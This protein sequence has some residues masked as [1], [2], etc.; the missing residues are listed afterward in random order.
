MVSVAIKQESQEDRQGHVAHVSSGRS[1]NRIS[2]AS[3]ART[4]NTTHRITKKGRIPKPKKE[5]PPAKRRVRT[6]CLTCRRKHKK[7]DENRPKC[8]FCTSKGLEC[9]WPEEVKKNVFVNNS[10]KD[11]CF[12]PKHS[13]SRIGRFSLPDKMV[14]SSPSRKSTVSLSDEASESLS[15]LEY[16]LGSDMKPR[17]SLDYSELLSNPSPSD[18]NL[19]PQSHYRRPK[20]AYTTE[21]NSQYL[22][23]FDGYTKKNDFIEDNLSLNYPILE[24]SDSPLS[25]LF[26]TLQESQATGPTLAAPQGAGLLRTPSFTANGFDYL[27]LGG[28]QGVA[29]DPLNSNCTAVSSVPKNSSSSA[30]S[31]TSEMSLGKKEADFEHRYSF[32]GVS[33]GFHKKRTVESSLKDSSYVFANT[34]VQHYE[35]PNTL[36]DFM[37]LVAATKDTA[38]GGNLPN[39]E[40]IFEF[41]ADKSTMEVPQLEEEEIMLLMDTYIDEIAAG[42]NKSDEKESNVFSTEI[43]AMAEN[44]P[45]LK[46]ALLALSSRHLEKVNSMYS[47]EKTLQLYNFALQQLSFSLNSNKDTLGVV[48]ACVLLCYFE[49]ISTEAH[50]WRERLSTCGAMFKACRINA[51]AEN[52]LARALFWSFESMDIGCCSIG[53]AATIIP[54]DEWL[55]QEDGNKTDWLESLKSMDSEFHSMMLLTAKV[56]HLMSSNDE[57]MDF[58][59]DW[60][61]LWDCLSTWEI[62]RSNSMRSCFSYKRSDSFPEVLFSSPSAISSNQLFHMCCIV[63]LQNKPRMFKRNQQSVS[64][65][66]KMEEDSTGAVTTGLFHS[67]IS[68][69][70]VLPTAPST[71]PSS[72]PSSLWTTKSPGSSSLNFKSQIWHAKQI[73]GTNL[74]NMKSENRRNLG[75]QILSLQCIWVA[76]KLI[77]SSHEHAI[78]LKLLKDIE[79]WCG[80][81]M[82]WRGKELVEF[83][84]TEC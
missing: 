71:D 75:C 31:I 17:N 51:S 62:N 33:N 18:L 58:D 9:V 40:T 80:V 7:C 4:T 48:S 66:D 5:T 15:S 21:T 3:T 26:S 47:G 2:A 29:A 74:C 57:K 73:I 67:A 82:S 52:K 28:N 6:G 65:P 70:S 77:S 20:K 79:S 8:D 54:V 78:I 22:S 50:T 12:T 46:Y 1:S 30:S 19:D 64:S 23:G 27:Q 45:A 84:K 81:W 63:M 68:T 56:F 36:R 44:F 41:F 32:A 72:V 53:E 24:N 76:G 39:N 60:G 55:S 61:T 49:I 69:G 38:S 35:L 14:R 42:L 37:C 16:H 59:S 25:G 11:F 43:P 10:F 13:S 83:W 34:A